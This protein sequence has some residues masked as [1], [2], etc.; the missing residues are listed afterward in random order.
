VDDLWGWK[1]EVQE[2]GSFLLGRPVKTVVCITERETDLR[3]VGYEAWKRMR[4]VWAM[5]DCGWCC[6]KWYWNFGFSYQ[7]V[8]CTQNTAVDVGNVV[9]LPAGPVS[10]FQSFFLI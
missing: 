9:S 7:N 6:F 3:K 4:H 1:N 8:C 5:T 2:T 10:Q